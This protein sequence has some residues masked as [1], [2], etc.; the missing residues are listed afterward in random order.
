[1]PSSAH[2]SASGKPRRRPRICLVS[3]VGGH[4]RELL[5]LRPLYVRHP[6]FYVVNDAMQTPGGIATRM[7]R[8]THAERNWRQLLNFVEA[9]R[10]LR[11]LRPD[12]IITTGASPAVVFGL[13]ARWWRIPVVYIEGSYAVERPTLT[14]WLVYHLRLATLFLYQWPTLQRHYPRAKY[15]GLIF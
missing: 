11:R 6:H 15:A 3:S 5:Q 4:F 1:M 8:M 14:G 9:G 10:M 12:V 7:L 13:L 2:R